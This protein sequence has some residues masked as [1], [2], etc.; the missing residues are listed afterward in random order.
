VII[1]EEGTF[2]ITKTED[3]EFAYNSNDI[4][5]SG[6]TKTVY[7]YAG[8]CFGKPQSES[9]W[10]SAT[11]VYSSQ[12]ISKSG[13]GDLIN[14]EYPSNP[15]TETHSDTYTNNHSYYVSQNKL[16]VSNLGSFTCN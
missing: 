12:K 2:A 16:Y 6:T 14:D 1:N 13:T 7:E 4:S 9:N 3:F 10:G 5:F 8:T 15:A 11:L